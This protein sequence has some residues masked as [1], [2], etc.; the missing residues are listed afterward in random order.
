MK[1]LGIVDKAW[2]S[3][4][5]FVSTDNYC[6]KFLNFNANSEFSM[7]FH[8]NKDECWYVLSGKFILKYIET[9]DATIKQKYLL[10]GDV[11]RNPPLL[12]H[13]IFCI[14]SGT[15]VEVSTPDSV[16]DNYRIFPG[17]SQK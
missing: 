3:E 1:L 12:P 7:H 15:I 6:G 16:E 13:Q 5:I 4:N 8:K 11:W 10:V 14:E 17:D 9:N 2:G